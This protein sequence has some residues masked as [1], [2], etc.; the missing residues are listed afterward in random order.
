[1]SA[2]IFNIYIWLLDTIASGKLTKEDID[3]RWYSCRYN[4]EKEEIFPLR[5]FH[6]YKAE[7]QEL[8]DIEIRSNKHDGNYYYI[9]NLDDIQFGTTRKWLLSNFAVQSMIEQSKDIEDSVIYEDMPGDTQYLSS[10][11]H[12]LRNTQKIQIKYHN[13]ARNEIYTLLLA[14]YCLKVFKQRWYVAGEPSTHQGEVRIYALDRMLD[15]KVVDEQYTRLTNWDAKTFFGNFYGVFRN[16]SPVKIR[17]RVTER[18]ADYL[19]NL[20]LHHSQKEVKKVARGIEFTY[21]V[22]PTLDFIQQ[23]RTHGSDLEVLEPASLV[24]KFAD[25]AKR[26]AQIYKI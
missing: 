5:K 21:Y 8:F 1:M 23:L 4:D 14:P 25:E 24:S 10:I 17:I 2:H 3:R 19:R 9:S 6:R 22:A 20:P 7:I 12:A 18:S 13:F 15:L 11:V 26:L 16:E